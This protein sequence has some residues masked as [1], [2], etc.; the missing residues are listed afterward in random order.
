[1]FI[2]LSFSF[3]VIT[4]QK[5]RPVLCW[6]ILILAVDNF[7]KLHIFEFSQFRPDLIAP[8]NFGFRRTSPR[9]PQV[10]AALTT[11]HAG[12]LLIVFCKQMLV[13]IQ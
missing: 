13:N 11:T 10:S 2:H 1:M 4:Q 6:I 5:D 8:I 3:T 7:L 9:S 12:S